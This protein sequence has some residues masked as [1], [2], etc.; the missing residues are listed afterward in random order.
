M[1]LILMSYKN[2]IY[3]KHIKPEKVIF[4]L[5]VFITKK[6]LINFKQLKSTRYYVYLSIYIKKQIHHHTTFP[7]K[8]IK[9]APTTECYKGF[10]TI[11]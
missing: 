9:K 4:P 2:E 10:F 7:P 1:H 6:I 5:F 11:C 8:I 3:L